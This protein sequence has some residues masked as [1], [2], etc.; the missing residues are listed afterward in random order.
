MVNFSGFVKLFYSTPEQVHLKLDADQ[1]CS[2][3][4]Y[5]NTKESK[6][7]KSESESILVATLLH[8]I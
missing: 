4:K 6:V 8:Q 1:M 3:M 5:L 2:N 7:N